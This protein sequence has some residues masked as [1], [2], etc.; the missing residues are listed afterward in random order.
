MKRRAEY[1]ALLSYAHG[2]PHIENVHAF[3]VIKGGT[4]R[5]R[6]QVVPLTLQEIALLPHVAEVGGKTGGEEGQAMIVRGDRPMDS[7][8]RPR[9]TAPR[10]RVDSSARW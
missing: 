8:N 3:F 6:P 4:L 2:K 5:A 7:A 1:K 9:R 10:S